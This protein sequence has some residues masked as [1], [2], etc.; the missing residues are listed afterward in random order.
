MRKKRIT[1]FAAFLLICTTAGLA[2]AKYIGSSNKLDN[3]F[4]PA[5]YDSPVIT[6]ELLID[7][8]G[9]KYKTNVGV[10]A[11]DNGYPVY[12]RVSLI[13]TWQDSSGNVFGQ[14]PIINTDYSL[15]YNDT[16]W[17]YR[18]EDGFYYLRSKLAGGA[19]SAPL[20]NAGQKLKQL[21]PAPAGYN[22]NVEI[23]AQTIQAVGNTDANDNTTAVFEA[24][25]IQPDN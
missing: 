1:A 2:A 16:D 9:Y 23:L 3:G 6:E 11:A 17:I 13:V 18:S 25:G 14:Q 22:M 21:N 5:R 24:W 15:E 10:T 8:D 7:T 20:I 19:A 4:V 12:A